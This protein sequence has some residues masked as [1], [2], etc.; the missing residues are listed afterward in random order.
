MGKTRTSTTLFFAFLFMTGSFLVC[1]LFFYSIADKNR[2]I[3][4]LSSAVDN[5]VENESRIRSLRNIITDTEQQRSL[6]EKH[7]IGENGVVEFIEAVE[8][9]GIRTTTE[10]TTSAVSLEPSKSD[11]SY[12]MLKLTFEAVGSWKNVYQF[13][14]LLETLPYHIEITRANLQKVTDGPAWK[15][16]FNVVVAKLK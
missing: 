12:E 16:S 3:S 2:N 4:V 9:L 6:L 1:G 11:T 10:V 14:L 7:F 8:D 13:L 5:A 15:G